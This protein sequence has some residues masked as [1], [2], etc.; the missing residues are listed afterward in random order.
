MSTN[1]IEGGNWRLKYGLR[2]PYARCQGSFARTALLAL[3]DSM[4]VF[5]NGRPE[6]SFAYQVSDFSY[7]VVMGHSVRPAGPPLPNRH[8]RAAA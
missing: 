3:H 4:Y 5:R 8:M 2:T 1:A 6:A 7:E